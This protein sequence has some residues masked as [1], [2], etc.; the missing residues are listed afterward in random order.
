V[1]S[2]ISECSFGTS[3]SAVSLGR[4]RWLG[5]V[6]DSSIVLDYQDEGG[7]VWEGLTFIMDHTTE[8]ADETVRTTQCC[9][10]LCRGTQNCMGSVTYASR[11]QKTPTN[12]YKER[13]GSCLS[14]CY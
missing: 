10:K 12:I 13:W 9:R 4:A 7:V 14:Y 5:H 3:E 1:A 6:R 8:N 11:L 2:E